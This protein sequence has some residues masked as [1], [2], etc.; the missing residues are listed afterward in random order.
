MTE[1]EVGKIVERILAACEAREAGRI[2]QEDFMRTVHDMHAGKSLSEIG[3]IFLAC[4]A[5]A[6]RRWKKEDMAVLESKAQVAWAENLVRREVGM[7]PQ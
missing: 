3:A 1:E 4:L 2:S 7:K 5:I 6:R